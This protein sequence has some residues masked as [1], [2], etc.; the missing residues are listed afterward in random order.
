MSGGAW[1]GRP[2]DGELAPFYR[3]YV[4]LV[5]EPAGGDLLQTLA[6]QGAETAALLRSHPARGDHAYAP[7]PPPRRPTGAAARRRLA[8]RAG[9]RN[10]AG[11]AA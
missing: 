8:A 5:P 2:A 9:R 7:A 10:P 3:R 6:A 4:A 11:A 1:A